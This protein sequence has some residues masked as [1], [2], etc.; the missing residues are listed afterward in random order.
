MFMAT[1][2]W[3]QHNEK[4]VGENHAS[5]TDVANRPLKTLHNNALVEHDADG[6]HKLSGFQGAQFAADAQ[7]ND[8]YV[9]TLDP[10]PSAWFTGMEINF[11][12][13]TANTGP[14]SLNPNALGAKTIKKNHDQ[15]L[16]DG[17][18]EAGQIIKV[19]YDGTYLQMQNHANSSPICFQVHPTM[20]QQNIGTGYTTVIFGTERFDIGNNF[21]S[22]T[23]TAPIT[24][25]Y[26]LAFALELENIDQAANYYVSS[27]NTSNKSYVPFKIDPGQFNGDV[28]FWTIAGSVVADMDVNDTAYIEIE[29][30]GGAA[31]TDI[32]NGSLF[33]GIKL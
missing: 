11:K 25:K 14:A 7:A 19:I 28:P 15:D 31:Q 13:N 2:S 20:S 29:Q 9:I 24:G 17:D 21:A 23:F 18:I 3:I 5:L 26:L 10:V 33:S 32:E 27:I 30:D 6:K 8:T 1:P 16:E 4:V 22:N 12:A